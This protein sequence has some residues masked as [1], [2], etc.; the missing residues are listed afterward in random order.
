MSDLKA[1]LSEAIGSFEPRPGGL[2]RTL[3]RVRAHRRTR[4]LTAAIVAFLIAAAGVGGV[5]YAFR[6]TWS[7]RPVGPSPTS[8]QSGGP[9]GVSAP[10]QSSGSIVFVDDQHGWVVIDGQILNT[11]DGGKNWLP[12]EVGSAVVAAVDFVDLQ[13]GWALSDSGLLRTANG[14]VT[15]D[16]ASDKQ[17]STVQCVSPLAGWGVEASPLRRLFRTADG[18]ETWK[19]QGLEVDSVCASPGENAVWAAGEGE[20]GVSFLKSEDAGVSWVD[21]PIAVPIAVPGFGR[22]RATVRCAGIDAWVLVEDGATPG[23]ETYAVFRTGEGGPEADPVL[24]EAQTRPVGDVGGI[25]EAHDPYAGQLAAL[26]GVH[27]RLVTWSPTG[28]GPVDVLVTNSA[29]AD[30]RRVEV[31]PGSSTPVGIFF[32]SPD[33]GWILLSA[34]GSNGVRSQILKT[35]DGGMTWVPT[36]EAGLSGCF[37]SPPG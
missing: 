29:G 15:W 27:A 31:A 28:G 1:L 23:H 17:L 35:A 36:C 14:G 25:T 7:P 8:T 16:R 33:A 21:N 11:S 2:D 10:L 4:R 30:W 13:H 22:W 20:G 32:T 18:G 12:Q 37:G 3:E 5:L 26:D 34:N 6:G 19:F 24:Q 9:A